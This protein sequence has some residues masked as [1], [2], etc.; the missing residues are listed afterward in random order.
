MAYNNAIVILSEKKKEFTELLTQSAEES[1]KLLEQF[2]TNVE[3]KMKR[4]G[5]SVETLKNFLANLK[6]TPYEDI[7]R[8]I[9]QTKVASKFFADLSLPELSCGC[10]KNSID[11]NELGRIQYAKLNEALKTLRKHK[12]LKGKLGLSNIILVEG[13]RNS[14]VFM[15]NA[16]LSTGEKTH[17]T[18]YPQTARSKNNYFAINSYKAAVKGKATPRRHK[19]SKIQ[20]KTTIKDSMTPSSKENCGNSTKYETIGTQDVSKKEI[21]KS[22][23][24]IK[25]TRELSNEMIT[26]LNTGRESL[27][28]RGNDLTGTRINEE[29]LKENKRSIIKILDPTSN[30]IARRDLKDILESAGN[31]LKAVNYKVP[32]N[33][34]NASHGKTRASKSNALSKKSSR[35]NKQ[36][37][38]RVSTNRAIPKKKHV[39]NKATTSF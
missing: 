9:I 35:G 7:H 28:Y 29:T 33:K 20:G 25:T 37:K 11:L 14:K 32:N 8:T 5:E 18:M 23:V 22:E 13:Q 30:E 39:K 38:S 1:K 19:T 16:G 17:S 3:E 6:Q 4:V 2:K 31:D 34:R 36:T 27:I 10:F 24:E 12:S 21:P 15:E 26:S